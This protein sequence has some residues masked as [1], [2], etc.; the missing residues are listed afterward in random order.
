LSYFDDLTDVD[1][2]KEENELALAVS[3]LESKYSHRGL[4]FEIG[5]IGSVP[6]QAY[7]HLDGMRFY[8]RFRHDSARLDLGLYDAEKEEADYQRDLEHERSR[9]EKAEKDLA[10]GEISEM[11][12]M[13]WTMST[14]SKVEES[15]K[16]YY[17]NPVLKS[18]SIHAYT[19]EP[20]AGWLDGK[21]A[22]DLFS[23]LADRL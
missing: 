4:Q 9:K 23:R 7:G 21:Q 16:D 11:D 3:N 6:V 10:A 8:F 14:A 17:P 18:V 15:N 2:S 5:F 19:G 20:Y 22:E 13:F 1:D 12:Y